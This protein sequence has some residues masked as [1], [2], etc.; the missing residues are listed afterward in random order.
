MSIDTQ[1]EIS[2]GQNRSPAN[3]K[4][5][6]RSPASGGM[7]KWLL[8]FLLIAGLGFGATRLLPTMTTG[9]SIRILTHEVASGSLVVSVTEQGKLESSSN[10]EI[11][12]RVKGG[13]TVLWVVESGTRVKAGDQLVRLDQSTIED[14]ISN[15]KITYET[16]MANKATAESDVAVAKIG[17]EEY[18]EGTFRSL[19]TTARK[20]VI[21]AESDL[22]SAQ[23]ALEHAE[24]MFRKGYNS[25]LDLE[26]QQDAVSHAR[27]E[28]DVKK[29]DLEALEKFTKAK[30]LETLNGLLKIAEA[31]LAAET[32]SLELEEARLRRAEDQLQNCIIYAESDGLVLHPNA[33]EWK[34]QPDIEEGASVRED[35]VL[36]IMPDLSKMQ[37]KVGIHESK[38][39]RLM[40]GMPCRI[41][42]QDGYVD[43]E[44]SEI[45][46]ISKGGGWW[47]GNMVNYDTVVQVDEST[48][49]KPGMTVS[50]EV[51]LAKYDDVLTVPVAA[52]LE[53]DERFYC[54]VDVGGPKPEKR[55]VAVG[56]SNDT[57]IMVESG[58]QAGDQVVLNPRDFID[59]A[60]SAALK[61][62]VDKA[63]PEE[64]PSFDASKAKGKS[65]E[66]G[67]KSAAKGSQGAAAKLT[68]AA[69]LKLADKNKD[70]ALTE[71]ELDANGKKDFKKNDTNSD[72]KLD[73]KE[74]D[75][76]IKRATSA[77]KKQK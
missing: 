24:K 69:I 22:K 21:I 30:E 39:D 33:A 1:N 51:F 73:E 16:A 66:G 9:S 29:T 62:I 20:D 19:Q 5:A 37:V 46:S 3:P 72:G 56:D 67:G 59:E 36:L 41:Q 23:N 54:W 25:K 76:A 49:L 77:A 2:V 4:P 75:A 61:P 43:G 57:F 17:I 63:L 8:G 52:V 68:G 53:L 13:S 47:N 7:W 65:A 18:L 64:V 14:N 40:V 48:N 10:V 58:L 42:L 60:S 71:D 6:T 28:L 32:A 50:V 45:A 27:L 31:R 15:Q 35:Q 11:K 26:A 44:V 74:L 70:G 12:C 38:V 34:E 55:E